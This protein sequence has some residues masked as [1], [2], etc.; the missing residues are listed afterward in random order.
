VAKSWNTYVMIRANTYAAIQQW[1][2]ASAM[3]VEH[4]FFI[5]EKTTKIMAEK[6][7]W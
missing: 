4:G 1:I 2:E 7:M 3:S 5:E 6:G